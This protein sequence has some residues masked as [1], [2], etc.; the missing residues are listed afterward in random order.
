MK[1]INAFCLLA[2]TM[3][4]FGIISCTQDNNSGQGESQITN[5]ENLQSRAPSE[6][7]SLKTIYINILKSKEY[8]AYIANV[9]LLV[10]TIGAGK[11]PTLDSRINF[12]NWLDLN[13]R[14]TKFTSV[15]AGMVLYDKWYSSADIYFGKNKDFFSNIQQ[16]EV[17]EIR[18]ILTPGFGTPPKTTSGTPCQNS[19]IS[20]VD[21]SLDILEQN[22]AQVRQSTSIIALL[23]LEYTYWDRYESIIDSFNG[24]MGGC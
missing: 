8:T 23:L 24:C 12:K 20:A 2:I 3:I 9:K 4:A 19:C 16:L 11:N 14:N 17:G 7:D 1:K 18:I 13:V 15:N 21:K 6:I 22:T 10:T 5:N